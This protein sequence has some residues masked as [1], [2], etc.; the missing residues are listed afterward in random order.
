VGSYNLNIHGF[1][2]EDDKNTDLTY[3][4]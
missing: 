3:L 2:E 4:Y 1:N